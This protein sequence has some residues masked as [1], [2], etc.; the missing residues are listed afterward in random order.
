METQ[1][2]LKYFLPKE[3]LESFELVEIQEIGDQLVI[4]LDEKNI[5]PP[6]HIDKS[7]ESK[8]FSPSTTIQ[9]F[10]IRDKQVLLEVRRRLWRDKSTGKSYFRS[11]ELTEKGTGYTKEFAA[12]LK[13]LVG[14]LSSKR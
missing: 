12:F 6:E 3:I 8:G 9:D 14:Q 10:P 2:L 11:W 5:L 13:E 7:L 4:K 1:T